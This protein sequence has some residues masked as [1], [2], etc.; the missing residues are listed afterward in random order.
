MVGPPLRHWVRGAGG[1]G[2]HSHIMSLG[3]L[4]SA[5]GTS[6]VVNQCWACLTGEE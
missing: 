4:G 5:R 2:G 1:G 6:E 3:T